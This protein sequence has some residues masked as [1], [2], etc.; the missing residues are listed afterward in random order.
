MIFENV[1]INNVFTLLKFFVICLLFLLS[2]IYASFHDAIDLEESI[3]TLKGVFILLVS[4]ELTKS[5]VTIFQEET[6]KMKRV[7]QKE[8]QSKAK[9]IIILFFIILSLITGK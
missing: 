2:S 4:I 1:I 3:L 7:F 6:V 9:C 8:L 5:G